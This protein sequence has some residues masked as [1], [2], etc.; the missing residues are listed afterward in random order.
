V[1]RPRSLRA[2]LLAPPGAGKGTQG[3]RLAEAFGVPHLATGDLLRSDVQRATPVGQAAT[4]Y[5]DRGEL[6]PDELVTE[7]VHDAILQGESPLEGFVLDGYP[8]TV[9][10]AEAALSWGQRHQRLF[11]VVVVLEVDEAELVRRIVGRGS[12]SGRSDDRAAAIPGR[13]AA[14]TEHTEPLIQ[15]YRSRGILRT[16]DGVGT[17]DEVFTRVVDAVPAELLV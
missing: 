10:Q 5:M 1:S 15:L 3:R 7:L 12:S 13:L 11:H 16:V 6:V 14:Y 4:S 17:V 2:L 9:P 8:R